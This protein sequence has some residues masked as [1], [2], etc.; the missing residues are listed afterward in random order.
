MA[1]A[2]TRNQEQKRQLKTYRSNKRILKEESRFLRGYLKW[3]R[4]EGE[5]TYI[6][7]FIVK[8]LKK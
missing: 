1:D 8:K 2:E 4:C 3:K 6:C 7:Q 5:E